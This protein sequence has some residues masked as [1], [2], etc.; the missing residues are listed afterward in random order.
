LSIVA[1]AVIIAGAAALAASGVH[2]WEGQPTLAFSL[3]G[4]SSTAVATEIDATSVSGSYSI[5]TMLQYNKKAYYTSKPFEVTAGRS[6]ATLREQVPIGGKGRW[7][8]DLD[9]AGGGKALRE[10]IVD[11]P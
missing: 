3:A 8:I 9:P 4:V 1:A 7:V 11:V 2:K 5:V 10:L 6:G